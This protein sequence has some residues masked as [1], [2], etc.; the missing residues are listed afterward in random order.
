MR[1]FATFS[2]TVSSRALSTLRILAKWGT[3]FQS[4]IACVCTGHLSDAERQDHF[5]LFVD[6]RVMKP[7]EQTFDLFRAACQQRL[8][9]FRTPPAM[10][11]LGA[12]MSR[13]MLPAARPIPKGWQRAE[14]PDSGMAWSANNKNIGLQDVRGKCCISA[15][16]VLLHCKTMAHV[17]DHKFQATA[18]EASWYMAAQLSTT[19]GRMVP[20]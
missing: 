9:S 6:A 14:G 19:T 5:A 11:A 8:Q 16:A 1:K 3:W 17:L 15:E 13:S 20:S 7:D 2:M 10:V 4:C 18:L 12:T